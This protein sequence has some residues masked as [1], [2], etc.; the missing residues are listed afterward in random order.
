MA[1]GIYLFA[2]DHTLEQAEQT[3]SLFADAEVEFLAMV[4]PDTEVTISAT[5]VFWRRSKIRSKATMTLG[6]GT[7]VCEGTISGMGVKR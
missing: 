6:D 1:L 5:K 2:L 7:L 3:V 4:P